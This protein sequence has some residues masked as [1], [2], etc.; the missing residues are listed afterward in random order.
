[1]WTFHSDGTNIICHFLSQ[2]PVMLLNVN[3]HIF[4]FIKGHT[5]SISATKKASVGAQM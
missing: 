4:K 2:T 3:I 1:M 5:H